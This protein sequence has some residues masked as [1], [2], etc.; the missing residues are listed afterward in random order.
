MKDIET[1]IN[2][3]VLTRPDPDR[4][5][6][7]ALSWFEASYGRETLTLMGNPEHK[8]PSPTLNEE[9]GRIHEFLK[10]EKED[11]QLT[12]MICYDNKTIGAVWLELKDTEHVKSP[13]FHIMIGNKYHRGR[14]F[15]RVIMQEM[16][17][18]TKD[19]LKAKNLYSRYLI[20]NKGI[21]YLNE[22]FGFIK[23]GESY[24]DTDGLEF[25]NIKLK[26]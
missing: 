5:A 3:L 16:I 10:L 12:W 2:G 25:Q 22:S 7:F 4:D 11:K 14:G 15:G 1:P 13:A 18:Y 23:D 19:V 26:F 21:A 20:S 8:I 6:P 24:K 17:D 9:I